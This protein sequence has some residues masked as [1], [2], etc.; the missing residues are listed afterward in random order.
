MRRKA[1]AKCAKGNTNIKARENTQLKVIK[2]IGRPTKTPT[3]KGLG[4]AGA[5]RLGRLLKRA[6][7]DPE[8]STATGKVSLPK[9]PVRLFKHQIQT[10]AE[11]APKTNTSIPASHHVPQLILNV[12]SQ[13]KHR[14]G[15][16]MAELK[17][18]L[19]A[20]G[21]NVTK[22]N[23]RVNVATQRLINNDKLVRTTRNVTFRLNNEK[24]TSGVVSPQLKGV[25][26]KSTTATKSSQEAENS[27]RQAKKT[28]KPKGKTLK[29]AAKSPKPKRKT[30]KPAAKSPKPK[31]KTRK[32][33]AKSPKPRQQT[34]KARRKSPKP[35]GKKSRSETKC[36]ARVRKAP[37][38]AQ[39]AQRRRPKQNQHPYKSSRKSQQPRP[40]LK[41]QRRVT[42]RRAYYY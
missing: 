16:S 10:K 12:V 40:R 28:P 22:N 25:L 36:V 27:Q 21:Y 11:N 14:G 24:Q 4:K 29:P 35:T 17:Q 33:A 39:R 18:T 23:R 19:A 5:K 20:G 1:T 37:R 31:G 38:K 34:P 42:R 8:E 41:T 32:P 30:R 7:Q 15:I 3:G 9:T 13:C 2:Q 26:K 6:I